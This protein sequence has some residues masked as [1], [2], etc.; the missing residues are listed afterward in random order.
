MHHF[1][2]VSTGRENAE[3]KLLDEGAAYSSA[4]SLEEDWDALNSS[5]FPLGNCVEERERRLGKRKRRHALG[6]IY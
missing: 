1:Q 3:V 6:E 2:K 5:Q 4:Q